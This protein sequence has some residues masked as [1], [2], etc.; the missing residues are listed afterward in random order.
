VYC[1]SCGGSIVQ[2]Q[3]LT[4]CNHCGSR[5][6]LAKREVEIA[7]SRE[8]NPESLAWAIVS[9]FIAGMGVIIG[10]MAVMKNVLHFNE[11][12][13]IFISLLCLVMMMLIE[14]VFIGRFMSQRI[15]RQQAEPTA[16]TEISQR[17]LNAAAPK[18]LPEPL[19]SVTDHTTRSFE[20]VFTKR[21]T[22]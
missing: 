19:Q 3:G 17:E 22:E 7:K 16:L 5:L 9:V 10:L 4:F 15:P 13:I 6:N 11:G 14:L 20:P 12:L 8:I 21:T 18:P 1:S 2:G